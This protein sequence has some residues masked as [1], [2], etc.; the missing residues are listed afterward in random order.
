[1]DIH[2]AL[3]KVERARAAHDRTQADLEGA[4]LAARN[5][6]PPASLRQIANVAGYSPETVRFMLAKLA[7][8]TPAA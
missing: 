4:I 3:D 7:S 1:M 2:E 5:A 8:A 6:E